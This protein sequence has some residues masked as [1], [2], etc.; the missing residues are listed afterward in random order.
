[1]AIK[2]KQIIE[3]A[4]GLGRVAITRVAGLAGRLRSDE[5]HGA[6]TTPGTPAA[7]ASPGTR[8]RAAPSG[9][10]STVGAPKPGEPGGHK[11]A[12]AKKATKPSAGRT[13]APAAKPS[14]TT[15]TG[16]KQK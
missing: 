9:S 12:T 4:V 10:P 5:T 8:R 3:T 2:P 7:E 1:M 6:P 15:K 13:K 11:S 16:A 14:S